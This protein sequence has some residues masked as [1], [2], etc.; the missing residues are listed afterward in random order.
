MDIPSLDW[1]IASFPRYKYPLEENV[2]YN[3]K[4][5]NDC[6]QE[7]AYLIDHYNNVKKRPVAGMV[8]EPVQSE[9]GDNFGSSYFFQNLQR[10][11]KEVS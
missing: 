8:I 2:E 9:G 7:V 3:R 5:D 11:G 4:Q 6:L 10:I 1:P